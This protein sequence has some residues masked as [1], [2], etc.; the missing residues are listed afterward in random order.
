MQLSFDGATPVNVGSVST[1]V[2]LEGGAAIVPG[3]VNGSALSLSSDASL[4]TLGSAA[5]GLPLGTAWT[6]SAFVY[7]IVSAATQFR[8]LFRGSNLA[9][10]NHPAIVP[11][12]SDEL[13]VWHNFDSANEADLALH[14]LGSGFHMN[15]LAADAWHQITA[16]GESGVTAFYVDG[17]Y[18]GTSSYQSQTDIYA[19][20]NYQGG[21]QVFAA[22]L[23]EIY[24]Y[25]RALTIIEISNLYRAYT[26]VSMTT[27]TTTT[28]STTTTTTTTTTITTTTTSTTTITTTTTTKSRFCS[29][30]QLYI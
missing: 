17:V 7:G 19:I 23:D 25:D 15:S 8:S 3:G 28:T 2:S 16:V 27:T 29:G 5:G 14:F 1:P 9:T 26:C 6:A 13:G 30:K 11:A 12:G 10:G 24:V 20:G 22:L 18:A 4:L 21:G